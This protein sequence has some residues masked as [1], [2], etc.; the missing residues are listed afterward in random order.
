M[1]IPLVFF[2]LFILVLWFIIGAKGH[3]ALKALV[4]AMTLHCCISIGLSLEGFAGWP[5]AEVLP[6][7]FIVHWI[8]VEEPDKRTRAGGAIYV[9]ATA[10]SSEKEASDT[11]AWRRFFLKLS[12]SNKGQPRAYG[13][14]YSKGRHEE[15]EG[16]L[17]QIKAGK[18]VIGE[19]GENEGEEGDGED[20]DGN[21]GPE[22]R[23][24][25]GSFSLSD[26][27][28]FHN[29]PPTKLPKKIGN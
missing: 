11:S 2:S 24:E 17:T 29:L 8:V 12:P 13:L 3:W 25:G 26:G 16:V 5:S 6:D 14:P 20:G 9:W 27:I 1:T 28:T 7:K 4:I 15:S 21:G 23:G 19:R 22:G 18:T 10:P